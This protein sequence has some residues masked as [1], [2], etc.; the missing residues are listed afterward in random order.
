MIPQNLFSA[1]KKAPAKMAHLCQESLLLS[2]TNIFWLHSQEQ[3]LENSAN[4]YCFYVIK[5]FPVLFLMI[6]MTLEFYVR[7]KKYGCVTLDFVQMLL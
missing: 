1:R 2:V 5:T 6:Y 4:D 3:G 7:P